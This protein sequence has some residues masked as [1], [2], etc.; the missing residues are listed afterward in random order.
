MTRSLQ[1]ISMRR[2]A[3]FLVFISC[4]AY[5][6][7]QQT[8]QTAR[9][10]LIE[11]FF[12][13]TQGT[14]VKHLPEF[15]R[16]ELEKAGALQN[17]QQY[18]TFISQIHAEGSTIETFDTG[19]VLLATK[20]LKTLEEFKVQV[21]H[22][23][24]R[25]G[26]DDIEVSFHIIKNGKE[27]PT[28]VRPLLTF[29]MKQ[30]SQIWKLNEIGLTLR[31]PLADP[32]LLKA[33]TEKMKPQPGAHVTLTAQGGNPAQ[34]E[35]T[36]QP[37]PTNSQ[38]TSQVTSQITSA[39]KTILTAEVTYFATYPN[40]GFTCTLSDLDGFGSGEP[41]EHQAMLINSGLASGKKYGYIFT[42]SECKGRPAN[43]FLL[44]A[45]PG[46]NTFGRKAFCADQ[47]AVIRSSDD[48]NAG[49]CVAV[50]TPVQ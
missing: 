2:V 27:E 1:E 36:M 28:P 4:V 24:L 16:T 25:D 33:I 26:Q 39:M 18:S 7:A 34:S 46:P 15:T 38:V 30:E 35:V 13:T 32:Q 49:T 6:Q 9:Q 50:G 17:M 31:I 45:V 23:A 43:S 19:T 5:S 48:G 22:E 47:S 14:F 12:S 3:V 21:E 44:T 37:L 41:N 8:P 40:T 29:S 10:A 20:N 42:L 11:M